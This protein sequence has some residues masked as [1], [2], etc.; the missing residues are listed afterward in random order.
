MRIIAKTIDQ[1]EYFI[2]IMSKKTV[3]DLINQ[4]IN[5]SDGKFRGNLKIIF[6]GKIL[7]LTQI[8]N[9][10]KSIHGNESVVFLYQAKTSRDF[11]MKMKTSKTDN[12]KIDNVLQKQRIIDDLLVNPAIIDLLKR[13]PRLIFLFQVKNFEQ[14]CFIDKLTDMIE[15]SKPKIVKQ[16]ILEQTEIDFIDLLKCDY[17][18]LKKKKYKSDSQL[19][20]IIYQIYI[21]T[22]KDCQLTRKIFLDNY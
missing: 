8:L 19:R 9:T 6:K 18:Q 1:D 5:L 21:A 11:P 15:I 7:Q 10:L 12:L 13:R 14:L 2:E 16:V 17:Q 3:H 20:S 4:L 22:D